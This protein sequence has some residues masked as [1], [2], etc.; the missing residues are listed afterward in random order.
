MQLLEPVVHFLPTLA[1]VLRC[2]PIRT[3]FLHTEP[4]R[5]RALLV[6]TSQKGDYDDRE[7]FL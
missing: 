3:E 5:E 4:F 7:A 1:L 6:V 2:L